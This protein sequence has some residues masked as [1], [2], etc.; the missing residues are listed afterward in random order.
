MENAAQRSLAI[1]RWARPL[2]E[3]FFYAPVFFL[4]W[5][6][7][8]GVERVLQ[9]E[10]IYYFTVVVLEVPSGVL[11]DRVGRAL[12]LRLSA[13]A[14]VVAYSLFVVAEGSFLG[15]AAAQVALAV[16]FSFRSGTDAAWHFDLLEHEGLAHEFAVREA[17]LRSTAFWVR[18]GSA[19][20][21]GGIGMFDLG[22][23]YA[24]S[25][26]AAGV[27]LFAMLASPE[28]PAASLSAP[29]PIRSGGELRRA[30]GYLRQPFL[31]WVFAYVVLKTTLEH[32]P[33][34]FMQP[35]LAA[36][37]AGLGW[38]V[39]STPLATGVVVAGVAVIGGAAA[40]LA[41]AAMTRFG[42]L[43]TLIGV[44]LL[45]T[46]VIAALSLAV[47]PV[48]AV[49]LLL[50]SVHPAIGNIV[51]DAVVA[52][53]VAR[54]ERATYLSLHSLAGRTGYGAVLLGLG[55]LAGDTNH[56]S[57]EDLRLVLG[58]CALFAAL[59]T[60][61]LMATRGRAERAPSAAIETR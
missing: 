40:R 38:N 4:Y 50:R 18:A 32:V 37:F 35:Y 17:R 61:A 16:H 26:I 46:A 55:V 53:R 23:P 27:V 10:A 43:Q 24:L 54:S 19:L 56:M 59:G 28:L 52:P 36:V 15:F 41:P 58:S 5:N 30:L 39:A 25:L 29:I 51:V 9:L 49:L 7:S 2:G 48:L 34:E 44:S 21:G 1:W 57:G 60:A 6:E 45:Q 22:A 12:T 11:S 47:H 3:A 31:A 14:G 20:V 42:A 33:H 13:A 8:L